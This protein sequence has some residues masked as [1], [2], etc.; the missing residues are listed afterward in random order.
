MR[1][2]KTL[3]FLLLFL[4]LPAEG[5]ESVPKRKRHGVAHQ[6]P[7]GPWG[8]LEYYLTYLRAPVRYTNLSKIPSSQTIWV[9]PDRGFQE[10]RSLLLDAGV[11]EENLKW[12]DSTIS[13]TAERTTYLYP[14]APVIRNLSPGERLAI[15]RL[16][17]QWDENRSHALP[18]VIPENDLKAW[19]RR[20]GASENTAAH[21]ASVCFPFEGV[22]LFTDPSYVVHHCT[23]IEEE[24]GFVRSLTMTSAIL[25][26]LRL[27]ENSDAAALADYWS[28][29]HKHREITPILQAAIENREV[30][31]L[32][33]THLLPPLPRKLLN[34]F[35]ALEMGE[36]GSYP[37]S[38]WTALNFF[39]V[40]PNNWSLSHGFAAGLLETNYDSVQGPA[41]FGDIVV[42]YRK[43]DNRVVHMAVYIAGDICFTKTG[44]G[45]RH[46]WILKRLGEWK[47][48][49]S[50]HGELG[51]RLY[52]QKK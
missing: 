51:T 40:E 24:Q 3:C 30:E 50:M 25:L 31:Y 52:R 26:R 36:E 41:R 20:G 23:S 42:L 7:Q 19:F 8:N 35:P 39:S 17:G 47:E 18:I 37:D 32:D 4:G 27:D 22:H 46:P 5:Q 12:I 43:K 34:T 16:L 15:T 11:A 49:N 29:G 9:F 44:S 38:F 10:A 33:V 13:V 6:I 14:P 1:T 2:A 48:V 28:S 21:A 45:L